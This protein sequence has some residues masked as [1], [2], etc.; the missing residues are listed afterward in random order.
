[1]NT[2]MEHDTMG[3]IAVPAEHHWGAQTQRS[4]E[5]FRIGG[6]RQP[7]EIITAFAY[8]KEACARANAEA[9]KLTAEQA[10]TIA[11]ICAEIRAGQWDE[12]FPLVVWQT[13]S[14]TQTNMNV[15][16]VIAHLATERGVPLHPNDQVNASQ[17]S[18]DTY[19]SALHI[20]AAMAVAEQVLPA[21]ERLAGAFRALEESYPD[22]IRIGRTHLQDATPLRFSQEVSGWRESVEA[23]CRM[24]RLALTE[25]SA[26]AIGGTAVGTGLNAP[27]GYDAMVC[28]HLC[29]LTGMEFRPDEN[30]FHA[31]TSK[32]A[33]VF[34]HG[35]LKALAANLMKIANDI[36]FEASGPRCGMGELRIPENEPGSS[37]MPGKVNP[38]QC[39]AVTMVAVQVMGN[40]AAIGM[41]ASQGNFQ[42]NVFLPVSAYNFLL[43]ARLLADVCDSFRVHCV[44]GIVPNREKMEENLRNS[45]M[46]VTCLTPKIGYEAAARC[47]KKALEEG[48]TLKEAVLSLGLLSGEEFD[49]TVR[50]EKMV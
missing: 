47:A 17:S 38:T 48:T 8:L 39:E 41:A 34:A 35:A 32:D 27:R 26:L 36:R 44:E 12:E 1:M 19:P 14:G 40:D 50:P 49:E 20:A 2:R 42:L 9:G 25:L 45:L 46:L 18:N 15:N 24:L 10:E 28:R 5:N 29:R 22:L 30:K 11:Q 23:P 6:Q 4:I 33:L 3:P 16:E 37:I 43:S 13:G 21:A 7:K 31:L